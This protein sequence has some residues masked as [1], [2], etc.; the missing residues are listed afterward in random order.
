MKTMKKKIITLCLVIALLSVAV[1]GGTLAYFT[2]EEQARNEFAIGKVEIDLYEKIGQVDAINKE[3][4]ETEENVGYN[5]DLDT[6]RDY[7]PIMPGDKMTKEISVDNLGTEGT[8]VAVSVKHS[9]YRT[10]N[11]YIDTYYEGKTLDQLNALLGRDNDPETAGNDLFATKEAA[12]QFI[13]DSIWSGSGWNLWYDKHSADTEGGQTVKYGVRYYPTI[14]RAA[15][16]GAWDH[17]DYEGTA[18]ILLAV[19]CVVDQDTVTYP[20]NPERSGYAQNMLNTID[21]YKSV[22]D[23]NRMWVYYYFVPGNVNKTDRTNV[24][25]LDLSFTCP[26]WIDAHSINAFDEMVIDVQTAAIQASGFATAKDAFQVVADQL[27]FA[28][29]TVNP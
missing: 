10:F 8:Y 2:D 13:T 18:P 4:L 24:I 29:N 7:E 19:D 27:G 22:E 26:T 11:T 12:M 17:R 23:N 21:A 25:N 28:T 14:A 15:Q 16:D 9:K 20:N 1:I 6:V 3:K 5:S